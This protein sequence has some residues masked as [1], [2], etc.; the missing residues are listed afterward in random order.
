MSKKRD[1]AAELDEQPDDEA[2]DFKRV[3]GGLKLPKGLQQNSTELTA[4]EWVRQSPNA[5]TIEAELTEE[6]WF[7]LVASIETIKKRY[8][9]YLGDAMVYGID[10]K[11]G[12][13]NEQIQRVV[14]LTGKAA[15]TLHEYYKTALLFE[16]HER[17]ENLD[18]E[19]HRVLAIEFSQDTAEHRAERLRW[20]HVAETQD[21]S[22][23]KLKTEI[24]KAQLS[25]LTGTPEIDV[26]SDESDDDRPA[27]VDEMAA[28]SEMEATDKEPPVTLDNVETW[29]VFH[30]IRRIVKRHDYT[31]L[32]EQQARAIHK[33][34]ATA[35]RCLSLLEA[36]LPRLPRGK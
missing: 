21:M 35:R 3:F 11:Y 6:E 15:P 10:R 23:R 29:D 36:E 28:L 7:T 8:Q 27:P 12:A 13:T 26:S 24:A 22:G 34:I 5:L 32:D 25:A 17:S 30:E 18:F 4:L 33:K 20:L 1:F 31:N 19:Q 16:I 14:E 2:G 9:W